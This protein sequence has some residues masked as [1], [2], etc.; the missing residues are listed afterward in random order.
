M[1]FCASTF[2]QLM[3]HKM[4]SPISSD[5]VLSFLSGLDSVSITPCTR[6]GISSSFSNNAFLSASLKVPAASPSAMASSTKLSTVHEKTFVEATPASA[7][8]R[9]WMHTSASLPMVDSASFT[10]PTV[11]TS[12]PLSLRR[13]RRMLSTES[14]VAPELETTMKTSPGRE[15]GWRYLYSEAYWTST[16]I[17]AM[18]SIKYSATRAA[19]CDVPHPMMV[20]RLLKLPSAVEH[21]AITSMGVLPAMLCPS[22]SG[23]FRPGSST[24]PALRYCLSVSLSASGVS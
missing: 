4:H 15:T 3:S 8:A 12:L 16:G 6:L 24:L 17:R 11:R 5:C 22:G 10:T 19:W 2:W 21:L 20:K 13:R 7:P 18:C 23:V 1:K 9:L 14:V